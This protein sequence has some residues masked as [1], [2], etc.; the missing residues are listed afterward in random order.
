MTTPASP[1][2]RPPSRTGLSA[3]GPGGLPE[4]FGRYRPVRKL[5]QGGMAE[6]WLAETSGIEGFRKRVALKLIRSDVK[7]DPDYRRLFF[8]EARLGASFNHP[9]LIHVHDFGEV[10]G[11]Y[12]IAMEL[13]EGMSLRELTRRVH[14]VG[15]RLTPGEV[16]ALGAQLAGALAYLH[17]YVD[18][19]GA[20]RP[21]VHRDVSPENVFVTIQGVGK[22]IDFGIATGGLED[23]P[24]SSW[25]ASVKGKPSYL[26]PELLRGG[27]HDGRIDVYGLGV[28]LWEIAA[29]RRLH[30]G[31]VAEVLKAKLAVAVPALSD[32]EPGFPAELSLL[33]QR[34]TERE[35]EARIDAESLHRLLERWS[36]VHAPESGPS[37]LARRVRRPESLPEETPLPDLS[38]LG[39]LPSSRAGEEAQDGP[40]VPWGEGE[41]SPRPVADG[42]LAALFDPFSDLRLRQTPVGSLPLVD[43]GL[44]DLG[45][46]AFQATG[47]VIDDE[48]EPS[49]SI[50]LSGLVKARAI[51]PEALDG[52]SGVGVGAA[53]LPSE[54]RAAGPESGGVGADEVARIRSEGVRGGVGSASARGGMG[55][56]LLLGAALVAG[57]GGMVVLRSRSAAVLGGQPQPAPVG[58]GRRDSLGVVALSVDSDP[59]GAE[60]LIDGLVQGK[61]PWRRELVALS[62]RTLELRLEGHQPWSTEVRAGQDGRIRVVLAPVR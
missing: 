32:L 47:N 2:P 48:Q 51:P 11:R 39:A 42:G 55:S 17:R 14:A 30:R 58:S 15:A 59:P 36:V 44:E 57:A 24:D 7:D 3:A 33:I 34:A 43:L 18:P 45:S 60:V 26:A 25:A 1:L 40:A 62:P 8:R 46:V 23:A 52:L 12:F 5:G 27:S 22:L 29:G 21:V 20:P 13:A 54:P 61:T 53:P 41:A 35:P 28:T 37:L 31:S 9:H 6:V 49:I 16:A 56:W 19:D 10:V 4:L 50:D 38:G